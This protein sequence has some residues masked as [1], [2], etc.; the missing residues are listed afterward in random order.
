MGASLTT[1][2]IAVVI[3]VVAVGVG[4]WLRG[5]TRALYEHRLFLAMTIMLSLAGATVT[6]QLLEH[7]AGAAVSAL[8]SAVFAALLAYRLRTDSASRLGRAA[9]VALS[10][11]LLL[12]SVLAL[13]VGSPYANG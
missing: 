6:S 3:S 13:V 12:L 2:V 1:I 4:V 7:P 9:L 11:F 10:V 5:G 8:G